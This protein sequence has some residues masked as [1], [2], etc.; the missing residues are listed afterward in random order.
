MLKLKT[1]ILGV[2]LSFTL[3]AT[4]SAEKYT[5]G[6]VPQ[7]SPLKLF[8]TW[9]PIADYLSE[10]T[11]HDITFKTEKSIAAFEKRLY[12]GEYD[13]AYMNPY[14]FVVANRKQ[15]YQAHIRADKMIRGI[16]VAKGADADFDALIKDPNT[17]YAF[18]SPNAFAATL[19]TKFELLEKYGVNVEQQNKRQYVN[20]HDSV[21]SGIA[22]GTGDLGGGIQRT[23]NN[24]N[25][26]T[27]KA[28]LNVVYTTEAYPSHPIAYK[29]T[30]PEAHRAQLDKALLA[31]PQ[32]L[33]DTLSIKKMIPTDNDEYAAI[34]ALEEKLSTVDRN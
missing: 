10:Q 27:D 21:Y 19:L 13:L 11:G 34:R 22:R 17:R 2:C 12:A 8:K 25:K 31:M 33:L 14:H 15:D 28:Q 6:V 24:F 4:A 32:G 18:P 3:S 20:S 26:A 1:L 30:L 7:Q 9:K 5:L 29:A 23:F 16:L